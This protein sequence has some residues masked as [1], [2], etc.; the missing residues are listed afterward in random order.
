MPAPVTVVTGESLSRT[1]VAAF[2]YISDTTRVNLV[3]LNV[4]LRWR[5][6]RLLDL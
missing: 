1:P 3:G 2:A 6:D 4:T 5:A